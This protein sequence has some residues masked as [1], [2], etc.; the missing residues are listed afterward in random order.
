MKIKLHG[1]GLLARYYEWAYDVYHMPE[2]FCEYFWKLIFALALMP[3]IWLSYPIKREGIGVRI[4]ASIGV[5]LAL[6]LLA[7]LI[8]LSYTYFDTFLMLLFASVIIVL[9]IVAI[10]ALVAGSDITCEYVRHTD[11]FKQVKRT[12]SE[13]KIIWKGRKEAVLNRYCPK[14]EWVYDDDK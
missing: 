5:L 14:I 13:A 10:L 9:T 3:L 12:A 7:V 8:T 6:F 4:A 1:Q 2:N 11:T